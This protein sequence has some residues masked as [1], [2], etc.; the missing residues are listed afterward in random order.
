MCGIYIAANGSFEP[1]VPCAAMCMDG[2]KR[3]KPAVRRLP[4][5]LSAFSLFAANHPEN[6]LPPKI[7]ERQAYTSPNRLTADATVDKIVL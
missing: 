7:S 5:K 1:K 2:R 3:H 4:A 6:E